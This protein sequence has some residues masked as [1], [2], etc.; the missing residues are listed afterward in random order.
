VA[1]SRSSRR[2]LGGPRLLEALA[3]R[4]ALAK[5]TSPLC[6]H[7]LVDAIKQEN[8]ESLEGGD[9]GEENKEDSDNYILRD[10]EHQVSKHPR[11]P[12]GDIDGDVD[13]ELLLSIALV[14]FGSSGQG[15]VDLSTNKEEEDSVRG[16]DQQ[17][18]N[19][20]SQEAGKIVSDP[21]LRLLSVSDGAI[22]FG[23][24]HTNAEAQ[25][26]APRKD[27]VIFLQQLRLAITT[28]DHLIEVE[29]NAEGPAKVRNEEEMDENCN[30]YTC[31]FVRRN[32]ILVS[33]N[34][35]RETK[36]D[37]NA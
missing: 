17:P 2:S 3:A 33:S 36:N 32:R 18:G 5:Q 22:L 21:A 12:D 7:L 15:F 35:G 14:G 8:E 27:M 11:Q 31:A 26:K 9:N 13:S 34:K 1:R 25:R 29:G 4:N 16:D 37:T 24:D 19:E 23:R 30:E 6:R 28:H 20:E 10:Q